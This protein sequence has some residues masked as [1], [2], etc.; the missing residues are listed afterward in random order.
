MI[1]FGGRG[2]GEGLGG[3]YVEKGQDTSSYETFMKLSLPSWP[4]VCKYVNV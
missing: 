1:L 4:L 3:I 2:R